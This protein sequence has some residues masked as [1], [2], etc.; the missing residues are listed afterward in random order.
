MEFNKI[1]EEMKNHG[2]KVLKVMNPNPNSFQR[3]QVIGYNYDPDQTWTIWKIR[4][5]HK[6]GG[7]YFQDDA[8]LK[9]F[10][11]RV[12]AG[13]KVLLKGYG[14]NWGVVERVHNNQKWITVKGFLGGFQCKDVIKFSNR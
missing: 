8:N 4:A 14:R 2:I 6:R 3:F 9:K 5:A 1:I 13:T 12:K 7:L 11:V 10:D